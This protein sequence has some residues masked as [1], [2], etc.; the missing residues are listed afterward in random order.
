MTIQTSS[1]TQAL[2]TGIWQLDPSQTTITVTAKKL[3]VFTVP[4]TLTASA[5][6]IEI[7]VDHQVVNVEI[8]ADATS[9]SSGNAK[10]D[11]HVRGSDF[12]DADNHPTITFR[13]GNVTAT[14]DGRYLANGSATAKGQTSPLAVDIDGVE[15]DALTGSFEASA[16][17]DR[18][19]VGVDKMPALVIGRTLSLVVSAK[20]TLEGQA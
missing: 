8:V 20:A 17:I 18:T 15:F 14:A 7:D 6:T 11:Q 12:L 5:G 19:A 3:G 1:N 2:P 10:R 13:T 9:Y 16:E 4:A